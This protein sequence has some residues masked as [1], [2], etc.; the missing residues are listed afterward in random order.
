MDGEQ[1]IYYLE[2]HRSRLKFI[3]KDE[4][5]SKILYLHLKDGK[6]RNRTNVSRV[7]KN[8]R[9]SKITD[10]EL[11]EFYGFKKSY[12]FYCAGIMYDYNAQ[13]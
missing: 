1:R 3:L 11:T 10:F 8:L 13:V 4:I 9:K 6:L 12:F 5:L 2:F 7:Y